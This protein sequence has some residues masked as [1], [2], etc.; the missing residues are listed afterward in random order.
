MG[1]NVFH[2]WGKETFLRVRVWFVECRDALMQILASLDRDKNNCVGM[3]R[4]SLV[5]IPRERG[6]IYGQ[7]LFC[8][9]DY[10]SS[11]W[12][13]SDLR[14]DFMIRR[15]PIELASEE[16]LTVRL[17]FFSCLSRRLSLELV[18]E[19]RITVGIVLFFLLDD[20][21]DLP[22]KETNRQTQ[23]VHLRFPLVTKRKWALKNFCFNFYNWNVGPL[24]IK[25]IESPSYM[26]S[27]FRKYPE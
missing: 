26:L 14:S 15:L 2:T 10:Q 25:F 13:R 27:I 11:L 6:V 12:V 20:Q 18:S 23:L 24:Y 8:Y 3:A 1:E 17:C 22:V 5:A 9:K 16:R 21:L 7:T 4:S 19:E